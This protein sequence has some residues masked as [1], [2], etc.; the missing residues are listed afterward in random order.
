VASGQVWRSSGKLA[1][2]REIIY[3]DESPGL[4]RAESADGRNLSGERSPEGPAGTELAGP[5]QTHPGPAGLRWDPLGGEWVMYSAQRQDRTYRPATP[6]CPLC[7]SRPG[8]LTEI[9]AP[10]Y[11]VVVFENRYP[12]L[13]RSSGGRCEVVCFTADH[14]A[15]FAD[16]S[17]R[18]AMTV[19][20]AWADRTR[21]LSSQ[22]GVRHV[23]CFENRGEDIGVTLHHPHGQVYAF[24]F[25]T[26]RTARLM[27]SAAGYRERAGGN[28]FDHLVSGELADGR[29]TVA[30]N[31]HWLAFVPQFARWPFEI[32]I[33][34]AVR[35]PDLP[36]VDSAARAAFGPVYLAVLRGL[37]A[38]F[39]VPMP[40][41]AAWQ[42][43]PSAR[44]GEAADPAR[45][46]AVDPAGVAAT[47]A[48][49][50]LH[51]HVMGVRRAPG[52][53]KY[54]AGTESGAGAWSNDVLPE[55]AARLLREA[56]GRTAP[57]PGA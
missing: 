26:P 50:G 56:G 52:K 42:Q 10:D 29:R 53:L 46:A 3:F 11:D 35:V 41:I 36:A 9:P 8:Q 47:R 57:G 6:E 13:T 45:E 31:E 20:E 19:F 48:E 43:A 18:R 51:L 23:Y 44:G 27:A 40:Y 34:P 37:D 33:F 4:G 24:P 49:F 2:G 55:D 21:E 22:S 5:W 1:D 25:V 14:D 30:R 15:S 7:P 32:M 12:A 16:L 39:D 28:L 38:L 17:L 54:L